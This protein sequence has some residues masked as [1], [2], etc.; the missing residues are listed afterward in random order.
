LLIA[1]SFLAQRGISGDQHNAEVLRFA[2]DD[3]LFDIPD[4]GLIFKNKREALFLASR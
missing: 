3:T 2:Q 1:T 4:C